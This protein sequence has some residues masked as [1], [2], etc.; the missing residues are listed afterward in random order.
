M[1]L[2][3]DDILHRVNQTETELSDWYSMAKEWDRMWQLD[4][5]Y[6]MSWKESVE[7]EGREQVVLPVPFNV[8][9]LAQR[10]IATQ[11]AI[12]IPPKS[13]EFDDGELAN[14][15][16]RWLSAA[17]MI[18]NSQAGRNLMLDLSWQM[19]VRG[20]AALEVK[21]VQDDL[22]ERLKERRFPMLIRTLDPMNVGLKRGPLYTEWA[23]HKYTCDLVTARQRYPKI[24]SLKRDRDRGP[25]GRK[26]ERDEVKVIDFWYTDPASGAVWNAVLV[27]DEF[28]KKPMQTDYFRI[29]ILEGYGDSA[30]SINP[31]HQR[32]SILHS[33]N[34]LWQYYNRLASNMA[35]GVLHYTWPFFMVESP[36]GSEIQDIQVRPGV[37]V[38]VTEGTRITPVVPQFNMGGLQVMLD[39]MNTEMQNATFPKVMYGDAGAMQA[40]FG[41]QALQSSA[42]NRTQGPRESLE[43]MIQ[44]ANE[45]MLALVEEFGDEDGVEL[46][47][48][49]TKRKESYIE[50]LKPEEINGYYR[51]LVDLAPQVPQDDIGK[52]TMLL[53]MAGQGLISRKTML[54]NTTMID[55]PP[56]ERDRILVESIEQHPDI[57]PRIDLAAFIEAHPENWMDIVRGT[58]LEKIAKDMGIWEESP[59]PPM[60]PPGLMMPMPGGGPADM[61]LGLMP[62]G[63][64]SGAPPGGPPMGAQPDAA[65]IPPQGGG[66]PPVMQGQLE[67]EMMGLPPGGDPLL[68]Q[69]AVGNQ[70][71]PAE[72]MEML[73]GR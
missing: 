39:M 11:P 54:D 15:I 23:F 17:W 71:P 68:F 6:S 1:K 22:P 14:R 51:N 16:E 62:P 63:G 7:E 49:D 4:S 9:N 40:G 30:P 50:R 41:V 19:L 52:Q 64:P 36:L 59:P 35:T 28:G 38:N 67:P 69:Q 46:W 66:I 70:I 45:L 24:K 61:P 43:M 55:V 56:D 44:D 33:I 53:Q 25:S 34:G 32:L 21:W 12:T 20:C 27:D 58:Q 5:G 26:G 42:R 60:L 31:A 37:T 2:E 47:A 10:L 29:P 18:A 8:V 72:L 3:V 48:M 73:R 13:R 65:A 57:K